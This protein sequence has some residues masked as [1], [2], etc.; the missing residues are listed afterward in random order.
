MSNLT[1]TEKNLIEKMPQ[2]LRVFAEAWQDLPF[3]KVKR[4]E[5]SKAALKII[6]NAYAFTCAKDGE[7]DQTLTFQ[8]NFLLNE[9]TGRF[10]KLTVKEIELAFA[11]GLRGEFGQYYGLSA[12]TYHQFL[13]GF[14]EIGRASCRERV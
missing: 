6:T 14:C 13:K 5:Q 9:L 10:A 4:N 2:G 11:M 3:E 1:L 7:N 12:K 8:T